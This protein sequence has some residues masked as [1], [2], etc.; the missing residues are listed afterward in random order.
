MFSR[1][2]FK[3]L[4]AQDGSAMLMTTAL[5]ERSAS[6]RDVR[7]RETEGKQSLIYCW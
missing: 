5:D 7:Q 3:I 1:V 6:E 2:I 4:D